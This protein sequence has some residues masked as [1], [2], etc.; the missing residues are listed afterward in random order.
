[1]SHEYRSVLMRGAVLAA[2]A[3]I[4][5]SALADA[6]L[7]ARE[8]LPHRAHRRVKACRAVLASAVHG[9]TRVERDAA[10]RPPHLPTEV[11]ILSLDSDNHRP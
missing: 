1:M 11:R 8:R 7:D 2:A 9:F 5:S 4:S 10:C 6:D 3:V